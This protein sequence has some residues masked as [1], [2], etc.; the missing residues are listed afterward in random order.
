MKQKYED[1]IL[2]LDRADELF[3]KSKLLLEEAEKAKSGIQIILDATK[4]IEQGAISA[5]TSIDQLHADITQ[6]N[7]AIVVYEAEI[8]QMTESIKSFFDQIEN[9]DAR[10]KK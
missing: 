10:M 5:K 1:L 2:K 9:N 3:E 4:T 8:K 7:K 6:S